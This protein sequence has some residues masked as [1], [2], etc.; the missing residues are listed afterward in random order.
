MPTLS[1]ANSV[2]AAL[3]GCDAAVVVAAASAFAE[4]ALPA[5]FDPPVQKLAVE[6]GALA[7]P[8]LLGGCAS[9]LTGHDPGRLY[10]GVLPETLSRYNAPS[11]AE[12]IRRVIPGDIGQYSKAAIILILDDAS[13]YLA[14]A[15][16][17]GRAFPEFTAKSGDPS[18]LKLTIVAIDREGNA[19]KATP[20]IKETVATT[21]AVAALVDTPPTDLDPASYAK[22]ARALLSGVKGVRI[23]EIVGDALVKQGLMGIHAV[24]RTAVS[25][26]RLFIATYTPAR[27]KGSDRHIALVGK[28]VTYDTGGLNL[29]IQGH[30]SNMK[31]DMGGSAAVLGAFRVLAANGC[32]HK[33]S[34][35]LC[36]AE[37]AI[38]PKAY[39]PDDVLRMH[40]GKTVE[41]NNT[42]A[43]GRLCL[44]SGVSY[45]ARVLKAD[46]VIDAATLTGAQMVATG[47]LHGALVSNDEDL[48]G[49]FVAAGKASGDL[50]HPLPF[51]PELYKSEFESAVADMCNS[52]RNRMNAQTAC[53]AQFVY[54]HIEDTGVKW[55]HIDLA[56]PAFPKNRG[57]GFGVALIAETVND[58]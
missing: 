25:A 19:I 13:H 58:L 11:R 1:F 6:L 52:V 3:K 4:N 24:G 49:R 51:A 14:A 29:K 12:G 30:M 47:L 42:D 35:I 10:V 43:E 27:G 46:T 7:K 45:A 38:G 36:L 40:S 21:R 54:W 33:V 9:T 57:T 50:V 15:N 8:G 20:R 2:R 37:N 53:A 28:G 16:A 34:V 31:C 56:G 22:E 23:K 17:V 44:A 26:P 41:I 5:L 18:S 39:K 55:A 48:E 32:K